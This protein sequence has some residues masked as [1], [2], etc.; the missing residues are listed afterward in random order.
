MIKIICGGCDRTF[1]N[2]YIKISPKYCSVQCQQDAQWNIRYKLILS[3]GEATSIKMARKFLIQRDGRRCQI[4]KLESWNDK[5]IPL[6]CDHING[7]SE[8]LKID[9]L[10]MICPNCD[11]QTDTYKGKN[12]GKGRKYRMNRYYNDLTY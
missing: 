12:K 1:L 10:R 4:C 11:A 5:P 9:D 7:N 2:R 8:S 3:T 6:V